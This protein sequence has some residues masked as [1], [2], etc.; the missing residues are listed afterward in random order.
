MASGRLQTGW[1]DGGPGLTDRMDTAGL[2]PYLGG[3]KASM[4]AWR[5]NGCVWERGTFTVP[6]WASEERV[7]LVAY[8]YKKRYGDALEAQGYRVLSMSEPEIDPLRFGVDPD[9]RKYVMWAA[10]VRRPVDFRIEVP[11]EVVPE[12][13]KAGLQLA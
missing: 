7:R 6:D 2:R 10:C 3:P 12:L 5:R 1:A 4:N 8:K 13:L 11:D 9:R